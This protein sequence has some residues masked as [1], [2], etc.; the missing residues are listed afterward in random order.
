MPHSGAGCGLWSPFRLA[1]TA[2]RPERPMRPILFRETGR[3]FITSPQALPEAPPL[4]QSQPHGEEEAT[5]MSRTSTQGL[6]NRS[7]ACWIRSEKLGMEGGYY[8]RFGDN[9]SGGDGGSGAAQRGLDPA[10]AG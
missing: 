4:H 10:G 2:A 5:P 6:N 7:A 9:A 3:R 1:Y 8:Q